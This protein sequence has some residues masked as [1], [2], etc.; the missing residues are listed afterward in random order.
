MSGIEEIARFGFLLGQTAANL[1][2]LPKL[3]GRP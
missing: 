1:E 3:N 2:A